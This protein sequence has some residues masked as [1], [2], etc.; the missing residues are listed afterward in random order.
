MAAPA[1]N[2]SP[3]PNEDTVEAIVGRYPHEYEQDGEIV[4]MPGIG[5]FARILHAYMLNRFGHESTELD[6]A[7]Q[8]VLLRNYKIGRII[9]S[10]I[11]IVYEKDRASLI[12]PALYETDESAIRINHHIV[13]EE[14]APYLPSVTS[15]EVLRDIPL[16]DLEAA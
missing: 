2:F 3:T 14:V 6:I 15:K 5:N 1:E 7:A 16:E 11:D 13:I 10:A 12:D 8:Q 9:T 4:S